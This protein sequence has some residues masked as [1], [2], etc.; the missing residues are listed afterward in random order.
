MWFN[1]QNT[2]N[3]WIFSL[4]WTYLPKFESIWVIGSHREFQ[5]DQEMGLYWC[6]FSSFFFLLL[7]KFWTKL[8]PIKFR[9]KSPKINVSFMELRWHF[10]SK[11]TEF[12]V[13]Q[14]RNRENNN[15]ENHNLNTSQSFGGRKTVNT[16]LKTAKVNQA[17]NNNDPIN[18]YINSF[19]KNI[20]H[21][22]NSPPPPLLTLCVT[23]F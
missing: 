20:F 23:P 8:A 21:F 19:D 16:L 7:L 17:N 4:K 1:E 18:R 13:F 10:K 14:S 5:W 2:W 6:F 9:G 12:F 15:L 11:S 22:S 3:S